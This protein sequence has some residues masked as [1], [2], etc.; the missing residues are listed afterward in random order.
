MNM[1]NNPQQS[2]FNPQAA[3]AEWSRGTKS[4]VLTASEFLGRKAREGLV[5]V[6]VTGFIDEWS[7]KKLTQDSLVRA[8]VR[9]A[10]ARMEWDLQQLKEQFGNKLVVAIHGTS[11]GLPVIAQEVCKRLAIETV[12]FTSE[13]SFRSKRPGVDSLVVAGP[14]VRDESEPLVKAVDTLLVFGG[15]KMAR[16]EAFA[17]QDTSSSNARNLFIYT[18]FG[19]EAGNLRASQIHAMFVMS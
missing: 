17:F 16:D 8:D 11:K 4:Q 7:G 12:G 1:M 9:T 5:V 19:G 14:T 3:K 13:Q 2:S 6:G 15:G 10:E 18:M